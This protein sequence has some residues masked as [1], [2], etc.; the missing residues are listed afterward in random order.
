VL[1]V[2]VSMNPELTIK[3][4]HHNAWLLR[5]SIEG[6]LQGVDTVDVDLELEEEEEADP[7]QDKAN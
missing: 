2:D 6:S 1:K 5:K 4:A 3:Q 7:P